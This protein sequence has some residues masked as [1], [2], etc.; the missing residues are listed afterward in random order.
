MLAQS[1]YLRGRSVMVTSMLRMMEVIPGGKNT[2]P[3]FMEELAGVG[4]DDIHEAV[5]RQMLRTNQ[6]WDPTAAPPCLPSQECA[7]RGIH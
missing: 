1:V 3:G 7:L 6:I 2:C 4:V 5:E